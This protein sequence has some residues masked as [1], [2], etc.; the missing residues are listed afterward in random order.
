MTD[1]TTHRRGLHSSFR[2]D[3]FH[4]ITIENRLD[5]SVFTVIAALAGAA[6]I[7]YVATRFG[8]HTR[9]QLPAAEPI[10]AIEPGGVTLVK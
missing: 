9:R 10:E 6:G 8:S 5:V 3:L 2:I 4:L 7:V 1:A